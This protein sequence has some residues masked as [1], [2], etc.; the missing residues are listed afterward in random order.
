MKLF[1]TSFYRKFSIFFH[2]KRKRTKKKESIRI[3]SFNKQN[4]RVN[5]E[6]SKYQEL[7][8]TIVWARE[9]E[10][11][12]RGRAEGDFRFS[13]NTY[14]LC[15]HITYLYLY[16]HTYV[17]TY[18][19]KHILLKMVKLTQLLDLL[20]VASLDFSTISMQLNSVLH[21][22][23][24]GCRVVLDRYWDQLNDAILMN[25]SFPPGVFVYVIHPFNRIFFNIFFH[26]FFQVFF[27]VFLIF[28]MKWHR[29]RRKNEMKI[30]LKDIF[31]IYYYDT[32]FSHQFLRSGRNECCMFVIIN[33]R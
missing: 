30:I 1:L 32:F 10:R 24:L 13:T 29:E 15:V 14:N 2:G 23:L 31:F 6:A 27:F 33:F 21:S 20:P 28:C 19:Y 16:I 18:T 17:H 4:E 3:A 12:S 22:P 7:A 5:N 9:R 8:T 25:C 26:H 11:K